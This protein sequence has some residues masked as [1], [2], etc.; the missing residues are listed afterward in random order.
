MF[1]AFGSGWS[2]GA[3]SKLFR[4]DL[5]LSHPKMLAS[6]LRTCCQRCDLQV[7]NGR[8]YMAENG[9]YRVVVYDSDGNVLKK[10]GTR[11]RTDPAGF[12]SC[13][14]PMNLYFGGDGTL[15]TAESG[16]G[17]IKQYTVAGKFLGVTGTVGVSRFNRASAQAAACSNIAIVC[18]PSGD[19]I[20]VM[21]FE[22][23]HIRVLQRTVRR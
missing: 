5:D 16:M 1:A 21:D 20:Y 3:K 6:N 11:S 15:Y 4:F 17:R 18:P 22:G 8:L 23:G 7:H 19:R 10:W 9:A 12:G 13:C 14:N 2:V